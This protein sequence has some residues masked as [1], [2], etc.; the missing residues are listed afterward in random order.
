MS[1][2]L[3]TDSAESDRL[4]GAP[5]KIFGHDSPKVVIPGKLWKHH[6]T[7]LGTCDW[8]VEYSWGCFSILSQSAL[9]INH[10]VE[11]GS[12]V[13]FMDWDIAPKLIHIPLNSPPYLPPPALGHGHGHGCPLLSY[14]HSLDLHLGQL[15]ESSDASN[16]QSLL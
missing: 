9:T 6:R 4:K 13:T 10:V 14:L 15:W 11:T 3:S 5:Q 7:S 16:L 1:M 12:L 2:L 8:V